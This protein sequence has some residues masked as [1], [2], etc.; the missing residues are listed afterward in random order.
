MDSMQAAYSKAF[1]WGKLIALAGTT[2]AVVQGLGLLTGIFIIRLLPVQE[3]AY[4]TIA[5]TVFGTMAL[6]SDSG[7]NNGVM[8]QGG[9]VW[10]S[11]QR[12][13]SVLSTGLRLR[14]KFASINLLFS[15]P[16]LIFFLMRQ[17]AGWPQSLLI[18]ASLIPAFAATLSDS[19]L[20]IPFK[21]HQEIK[22]LQVNQLVVSL[23]RFIL[24]VLL[25]IAFPWTFVSLLSNGIPRLYGNFKLRQRLAPL[26]DVMQ[27][28]DNEANQQMVKMVKRTLPL[29]LFYAYSSQIVI[30]LVSLSGTTTAVAQI[31]ALGRISTILSIVSILFATMIIPRF[32][33]LAS[34]RKALFAK[35]LQIIIGLTTVCLLLILTCHQFSHAI[36]SILGK[37]Y[38]A[39]DIALVL[40]VAGGAINL[41]SG[42]LYGLYSSR[43]WTIQ[44]FISIGLSL[45]GM[46]AGIVLLNVST[47]HGVLIFN[48]LSASL[49]LL[50]NLTF[51]GYKISKL[52]VNVRAL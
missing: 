18:A 16:V 39:L 37:E 29:T 12:L 30:W 9:Q 45:A 48:L 26:A 14:R 49:Q 2:Q 23:G 10:Q 46:L 50:I 3:Y 28:V 43:G 27:P 6:L 15:I 42:A 1:H 21:L 22:Y 5:N 40:S 32:A 36:L 31:G 41:V 24:S 8:A 13:G 34:D 35:L 11:P 47:L 17:G 44:P 38:A 51:C 25:L 33:R 19:V 20:E 52:P 4:Y 7:I